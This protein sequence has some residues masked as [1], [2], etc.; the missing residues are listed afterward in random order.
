MERLENC[1][2]PVQSESHCKCSEL[3][4]VFSKP[5]LGMVVICFKADVFVFYMAY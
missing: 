5:R 4:Y 3:G 2:Y 1:T